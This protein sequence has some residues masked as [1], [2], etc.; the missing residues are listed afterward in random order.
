MALN[1]VFIPL[2][3]L[4][5]ASLN[6]IEHNDMKYKHINYGSGVG[7]AF[8]DKTCFCAKDELNDFE[9]G[10]AY[11]NWLTLIK[12]VSDPMDEQGWHVHHKRMTVDCKFLD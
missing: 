6:R 2:S 9:F 5:T 3:M 11:M 10:Q 12:T 7:K 8:L 1:K 4:M